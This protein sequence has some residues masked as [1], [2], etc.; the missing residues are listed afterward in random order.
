M[1]SSI[2]SLVN[3]TYLGVTDLTQGLD[4]SSETCSSVK[5]MPAIKKT[6]DES[7]IGGNLF[8][9]VLFLDCPNYGVQ[10]NRSPFSLFSSFFFLREESL[11]IYLGKIKD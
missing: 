11:F 3:D 7:V 2:N 10:F 1:N 8:G 4:R 9:R 5:R 6:S